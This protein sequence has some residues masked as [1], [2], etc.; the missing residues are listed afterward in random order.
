MRRALFVFACAALFS[1]RSAPEAIAKAPPPP[2]MTGTARALSDGWT[3]RW[4]EIE[5]SHV[6]LGHTGRHTHANWVVFDLPFDPASS[7][8]RNVTFMPRALSDTDVAMLETPFGC[9]PAPTLGPVEDS[10]WS[11]YTLRGV[12]GTSPFDWHELAPTHDARAYAIN[13]PTRVA[14]TAACRDRSLFE[15]TTWR[16]VVEWDVRAT[17]G[18]DRRRSPEH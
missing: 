9:L 11:K 7:E 5:A 8:I 3:R 17:T 4:V 6:D 2:L 18:E 10:R 13:V 1:E 14:N 15:K 12:S 16:L